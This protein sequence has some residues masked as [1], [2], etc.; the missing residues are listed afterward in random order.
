MFKVTRAETPPIPE[1]LSPEGQSFIR[2]CLQRNPA[3]R[4]S[5][6]Q[7]LEHSFVQIPDEV[8][9]LGKHLLSIPDFLVSYYKQK[10]LV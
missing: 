1:N 5:A 4:P 6:A 10:A 9:D 7:L 8:P 3:D 2:F